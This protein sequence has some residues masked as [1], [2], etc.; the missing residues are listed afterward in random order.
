[1]HVA[2][3]YAYSRVTRRVASRRVTSRR[4]A[5][6]RSDRSRQRRRWRTCDDDDDDEDINRLGIPC[7]DARDSPK[8][9]RDTHCINTT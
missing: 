4:V 9:T 1:M 3:G 7:L 5:L 2:V 8:H 6:R